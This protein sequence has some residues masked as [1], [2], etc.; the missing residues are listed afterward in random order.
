[1]VIALIGERAREAVSLASDLRQ[2][3]TWEKTTLIVATS[4]EPAA[5]RV[6]AAWAAMELAQQSRAEGA[7]ALVL[8]DSLT[9]WVRARRDLSLLAGE[10]AARGGFP[11]SAFAAMAPLVE[12]A[13]AT[14]SGAITAFFTVL[15]EADAM[16]DPIGDEA[17]GLVEAH[18]ILSR[19]LAQRNVFPAIDLRASLSRLAG[20]VL[21]DEQSQVYRRLRHGFALAEELQE[22]QR[23]GLYTPGMDAETDAVHAAMPV[24]LQWMRQATDETHDWEDTWQ[25][26]VQLYNQLGALP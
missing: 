24:L 4:D 19:A 8:V 15:L 9:R 23:F 18:W 25:R 1:M 20:D 26:S 6:R 13:G 11:P 7:H 12:A 10:R 3:P 5:L 22:A 17:R 16:E 21:T 2:L 14:Q